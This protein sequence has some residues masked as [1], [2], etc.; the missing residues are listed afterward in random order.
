MYQI[1]RTHD[2]PKGYAY[3]RDFMCNL[4]FYGTIDE[5][6]QFIDDMNGFGGRTGEE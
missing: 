6:I 1:Y 5:C 3:V 2:C 4:V